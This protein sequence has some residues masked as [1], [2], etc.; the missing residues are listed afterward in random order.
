MGE[1]WLVRG[2]VSDRV[3]RRAGFL[4]V[5]C[6]L[7]A[8]FVYGRASASVNPEASRH[9]TESPHSEPAS[10]DRA[11]AGSRRDNKSNIREQVP[12]KH[13]KRYL[14]WKTEFLSTESGRRQWQRFA[15]DDDFTLTI[16]VSQEFGGG[17]LVTDYAWNSAG[18][19]VAARIILG[20]ELDGGI[21]SPFYYPVTGALTPANEPWHVSGDVLA[22]VKMA[23]EFGHVS[24]AAAADPTLY[25][26]Q[27]RLIAAYL[28]IFKEN[29][30]KAL[31]PR[32]TDLSRR[33]EGTPA[34]IKRLREYEAETF[35]LAFVR[36]RIKGEQGADAL[37]RRMRKVIEEYAAG[38][39]QLT[40]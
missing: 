23:H 8:A 18:K 27:N 17:G 9:S 12:G 2:S 33:L 14:R 31:D 29:G 19:L 37:F 26:Q 4:L 6:L 21:L 28:K 16:T 1:G 10:A 35:A 22:A 24:S 40:E 34:D 30:Y 36:E 15:E 25:Q 7:I 13:L 39:I 32:L 11:S 20:S 5:S 38:H 3:W